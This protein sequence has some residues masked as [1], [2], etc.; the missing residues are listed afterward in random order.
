[1]RRLLLPLGTLVVLLVVW[2]ASVAWTHVTPLILPTP[3][4]IAATALDNAASLLR[5]TAYTMG[6]AVLGFLLGSVIAYSLAILFVQFRSAEDAI[7]P[8][9]IALK[10]T[11]LIAL[12]PLIVLWAGNG[13]SSK[14]IMSAIVAFWPVLVAG[15]RGLQAVDSEALD[16]MRSLGASRW[17]VLTKIR[18]PGSMG[19]LFASFKVASSLSVVG[20]IIG[21]LVGS[22]RGIGSVINKS[23]YYLETA[24]VFAAIASI[25]IAAVAFFGVIALAEKRLVF[26]QERSIS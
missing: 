24:L 14:V 13:F 15:L 5:E 12:A 2:E 21:E 20:A 19:Y 18:I 26:W 10:S 7:M 8:Y 1:M 17:Q 9:A 3:R 16:L 11:P 4:A 25:S 22:T 23:S 6:E